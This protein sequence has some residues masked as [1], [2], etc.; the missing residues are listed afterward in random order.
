[1][2]SKMVVLHGSVKPAEKA[3]IATHFLKIDTYKNCAVNLE[4]S[5]PIENLGQNLVETRLA[6]RVIPGN[7]LNSSARLGSRLN[8][9]LEQVEHVRTSGK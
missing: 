3:R 6:G 1:M 8:A 9:Y 7:N 4:G 5:T 2:Y